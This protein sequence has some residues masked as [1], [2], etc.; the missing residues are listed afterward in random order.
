MKLTQLDDIGCFWVK[1]APWSK[2]ARPCHAYAA[3]MEDVALARVDK[4]YPNVRLIFRIKF[5]I[6]CAAKKLNVDFSTMQSSLPV[7]KHHK[8]SN[9]VLLIMRRYMRI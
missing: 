6:M 7:F 9:V 5:S 2:S 8:T 4:I 3:A 1:N